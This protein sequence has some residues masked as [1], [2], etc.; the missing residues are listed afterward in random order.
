MA[1]EIGE[2]VT[3]WLGHGTVVGPLERDEENVAIQRVKFDNPVFGERLRPVD[4][5]SPLYPEDEVKAKVRTKI[6]KAGG[7]DKEA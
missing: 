7:N 5:M 3:S 4:K 6:Q 1:F 2:R